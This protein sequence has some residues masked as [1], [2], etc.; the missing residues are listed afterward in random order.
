[1]SILLT[2][3]IAQ[4]QVQPIY[5]DDHVTRSMCEDVKIE[6]YDAADRGWITRNQAADLLRRCYKHASD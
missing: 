5:S 4:A 3:L 1:M 2:I 6:L